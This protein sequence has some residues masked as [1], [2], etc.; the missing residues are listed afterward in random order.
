MFNP[1][2]IINANKCEYFVS[3]RDVGFVLLSI[4]F[5]LIRDLLPNCGECSTNAD[6]NKTK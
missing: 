6:V 1:M 4:R 5:L 2:E 3:Y